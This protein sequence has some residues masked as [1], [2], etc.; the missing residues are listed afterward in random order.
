MS[1]SATIAHDEM[2][3]ALGWAM[4]S[5]GVTPPTAIDAMATKPVVQVAAVAKIP[6]AKAAK[7]PAKVEEDDDLDLG[8]DDDEE[9]EEKPAAGNSRAEQAKALKEQRDKELEEKKA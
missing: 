3:V 2:R 1:L 7:A 9:E 8:F 4:M 5:A 6:A